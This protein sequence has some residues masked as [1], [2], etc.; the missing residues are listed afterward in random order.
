MRIAEGIEMLEITVGAGE[1]TMKLHPTVVYDSDSWVLID[2]G[3]PGCSAAI[4]EQAKQA[5]VPEG[6]PSAV[7]L[8]HQDIDHVGGLPEWLGAAGEGLPVYA[9]EGDRDA[10]DGQ[11]P[12]LKFTPQRRE[13]LL[14]SLPEPLRAAFE[15]TFAHPSGPNVTRLLVDGETLPFGGGLTVIHT[16]GHTPG[17]VALYHRA[18]KTLIAA[19]SLVVAEGR[20]AGPNPANTPDMEQALKSLRRY[21]AFDIENVICYHGGL[22]REE[23]NE[24]IAEL[25]GQA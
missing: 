18:S 6:D 11:A 25:A 23:A 13:Q 10:I 7:V 3:M 2:T 24:R 8:T 5:G 9:H 19:D 12:F 16:P 14:P 22:W 20:L 15:K 17:H 4:R 1:R 21:A